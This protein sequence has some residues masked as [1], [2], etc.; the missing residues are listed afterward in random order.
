MPDMPI[1]P[2]PALDTTGP[3]RPS[4]V[5]SITT[6]PYP[7]VSTARL[8]SGQHGLA[9]QLAAGQR[10][11]RG[12]GLLPVEHQADLR[13]QPPVRDQPGQDGEIFALGLFRHRADKA[14]DLAVPGLPVEV[15]DADL[16]RARVSP[17]V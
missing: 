6:A 7:R 2:S 3:P 13:L 17:P 10:G 1:R 15:A 9:A 4:V 12:G 5:V 8:P 16:G 11:Q 14:D